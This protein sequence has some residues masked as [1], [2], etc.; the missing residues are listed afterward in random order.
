MRI[1]PRLSALPDEQGT[2]AQAEAARADA[3]PAFVR[4]AERAQRWR[5]PRVR[6]ALAVLALLGFAGLAAQAL[7]EYRD[8][9]AARW[10]GLRP[11][12]EHACAVTG[13]RIA[14]PR[15]IEG[16][17]VDSSGLLR[18]EGTDLY[19]LSIVLRNRAGMALAPPAVELSLT[20]AKGDMIARKVLSLADLGVSRES[21]TPGSSVPLQAML[22]VAD[23]PVTGYTIELFYP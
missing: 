10:T 18:T 13:C 17:V 22:Q 11:L 19:K 16:L 4:R 9:A 14:A 20:D 12:L 23:G 5:Q 8:I 3:T 15:L 7:L 1:E 21:V 6:A 2:T